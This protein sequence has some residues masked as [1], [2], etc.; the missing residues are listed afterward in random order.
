MRH[1]D[2]AA[3]ISALLAAPARADESSADSGEMTTYPRIEGALLIEIENDHVFRSDDPGT[4]INDLFTTI[5]L[6]TGIYA[7]QNF[8]LQTLIVLE[9]VLD[10]RPFEDRTFGDHGAYF[11]ELHAQY[12][13][14]RI[15]IFA[16]KFDASFGT[17]WD[18]APG[19]FGTSFAED[20]E[21]VERIGGGVAATFETIYLG[22][23]ILT[24]NAFFTDTTALSESVFTNTGDEPDGLRAVPVTRKASTLSRSP[25]TART[26]PTH[27]T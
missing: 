17:A 12:E 9:P 2:C 20:Y 18:A 26:L 11:E 5:E 21:L 22:S 7:S 15:R 23:H 1:A 24:V 19:V 3:G 13:T 14:D 25:S 27:R 10:P 6:A 4:E 8:S 16:G